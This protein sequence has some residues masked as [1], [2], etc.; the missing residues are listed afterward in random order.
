MLLFDY[1]QV[2]LGGGCTVRA[3]ATV[4]RAP[5]C[6]ARALAHAAV[7]NLQLR[8]TTLVQIHRAARLDAHIPD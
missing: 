6:L 5:K 2:V 7:S 4:L 3:A 8:R 1:Q